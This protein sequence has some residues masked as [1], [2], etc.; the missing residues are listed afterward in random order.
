AHLE[1]STGQQLYK[2]VE[3]KWEKPTIWAKEARLPTFHTDEPFVYA[4]IRNHGKF[5]DKDRIEYI[6]LTSEPSKRFGNHPK[7]REIVRQ[8]G[9]I[10]FTYA[11]INITRGRNRI[12]R[13][14]R[15]LEEIEH[16]LIWTLWDNLWNDR[17]MF[18]L[19]GFGSKG[20]NAWHIINGGYRFSG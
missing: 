1:N 2:Q 18:T 15:A 8:K 16:L 7:A 12:E 10:R 11:P 5:R 17:K 14:K 20:G 3:L 19:P 9:V 4:L 13:L 6:G